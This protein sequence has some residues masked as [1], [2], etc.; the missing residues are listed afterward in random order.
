[1]CRTR[2][3]TVE[4]AALEALAAGRVPDEVTHLKDIAAQHGLPRIDARRLFQL[5]RCSRVCVSDWH[6]P[7]RYPLKPATLEHPR[8]LLL[9]LAEQSPHEAS[10]KGALDP[11]AEALRDL[12][13]ECGMHPHQADHAPLSLLAHFFLAMFGK[14]GCREPGLE[15]DGWEF[16]SGDCVNWLVPVCHE[17]AP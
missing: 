4:F 5:Q 17:E 16:F 6:S 7:A 15:R 10:N 1:M 2:C 11:H 8:S 3:R 12:A 9:I 13:D 14:H